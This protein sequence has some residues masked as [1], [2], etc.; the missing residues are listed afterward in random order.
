MKSAGKK[1]DRVR[2][3]PVYVES[4]HMARHLALGR[5]SQMLDEQGRA[6]APSAGG[7]PHSLHPRSAYVGDLLRNRN[8]D[9]SVLAGKSICVSPS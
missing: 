1:N 6:E 9:L 8:G 2:V 5:C 3:H 4:L 7:G